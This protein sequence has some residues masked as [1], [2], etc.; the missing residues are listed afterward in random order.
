MV[1]TLVPIVVVATVEDGIVGTITIQVDPLVQIVAQTQPNLGPVQTLIH[2]LILLL[3]TRFA[4]KLAI[5]HTNA[6]ATP[7]NLMVY[8][9]CF[10]P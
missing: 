8:L 9:L 4:T 10:Q 2:A 6:I 3:F 5:M 7:I 1:A